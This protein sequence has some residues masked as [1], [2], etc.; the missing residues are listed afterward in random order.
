M[1]KRAT[2]TSRD[3]SVHLP[4]VSPTDTYLNVE[5]ILGRG[6]STGAEAIHPGY[7]FL[8]E[9]ADFAEAVADAGL[10]WIGPPPEATRAVGDKIAA[11]THRASPQACPSCRA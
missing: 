8:S 10:V 3:E 11:R 6:R 5:A 2:W 9:N 1:R 7:G 4:G